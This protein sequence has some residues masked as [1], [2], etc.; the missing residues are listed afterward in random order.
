[1]FTLCTLL[2]ISV[3]GQT[4]ASSP[5]RFGSLALADSELTQIRDIANGAGGNA[6]LVIGFP[7]MI[8]GVATVTVYLQ[9]D[10]KGPRVSRGRLLVLIADDPP[11]V[12]H[13]SV[14]K[15]K[16][17]RSYAY[18]IPPGSQP[19]QI[20]DE[21]DVG[22]PFVVEGEIDD[23]TLFSLV[24]FIRSKPQIPNVPAGHAPQQV[25]GAPISAV[26]G[27]DDQFI[28]AL[29]TSEATGQRVTVTWRN[30]QWTI[31][32]FEQWIV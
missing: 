14:W 27:R 2:I 19:F 13:R 11:V 21:R 15:I 5:A 4:P 18:V 6:W 25:G 32:H 24:S 9:P 12:P 29:R 23:R 26:V 31:A 28:V 8:A 7:S 22:W 20:S 30:G 16:E 3:A 1:M 10:A 17:A